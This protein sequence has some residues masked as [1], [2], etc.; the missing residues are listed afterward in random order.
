MGILSPKKAAV[1]VV[2]WPGSSDVLQEIHPLKELNHPN[3]T[4]LFE[5]IITEDQVYLFMQHMGE[6]TLLDYL[7]ELW[8]RD[9]E[10]SS[11]PVLKIVIRGT[12]I[13]NLDSENIHVDD[14]M[15][16]KLADFGF[17]RVFTE[18]KLITF[19]G[20]PRYVAPEFQLE[21]S[22]GPKVEVWSK[23]VV[24]SGNRTAAIVG[25]NFEEFTEYVLN[26]SFFIPY[27][28]SLQCQKLL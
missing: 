17:S 22:E 13:R 12:V 1:K 19:Y 27:F 20:I 25:E 5:V 26:G 21:S 24:L 10:G 3:I 6:G 8:P 7:R 2:N 15:D 23:E 9:R 18:E 16:V 28:L 14:E 4:N 11:S